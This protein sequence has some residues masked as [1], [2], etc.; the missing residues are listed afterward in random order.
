MLDFRRGKG[1]YMFIL[2]TAIGR[3]FRFEADVNTRVV[4]VRKWLVLNSDFSSKAG[5]KRQGY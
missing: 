3:G 1:F 5:F 4:E 2:L